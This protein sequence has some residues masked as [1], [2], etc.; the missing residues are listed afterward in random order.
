MNCLY[1]LAVDG[2]L[3]FYGANPSM[4]RITAA[5]R[6]DLRA[7]GS[8]PFK[9]RPRPMFWF[10]VERKRYPHSACLIR[11]LKLPKDSRVIDI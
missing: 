1:Y 10:H 5:A 11:V 7:R 2:T 9:S 3:W 6:D 4:E 8:S